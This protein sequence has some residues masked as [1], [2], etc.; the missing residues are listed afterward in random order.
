MNFNYCPTR[1]FSAKLTRLEKTDPPGFR[2]VRSVIARILA[3]PEDADG[4]MHG[5]HHRRFK[6]YVGRSD[7]RLIYEWCELCR[8]TARKVTER[9]D[10]CHELPDH[11]VVF[12]DVF[13]K[14]E[15]A[16]L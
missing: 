11:S 7:Y 16:N 2:R 14:N 13:H 4:R 9:C 15:A 10:N 5:K 1:V 8:K 12:F 6:K 3:N